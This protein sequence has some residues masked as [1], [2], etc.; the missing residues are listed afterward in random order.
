MAKKQ[1]LPPKA[2]K[3]DVTLA[4]DV[5]DGYICSKCGEVYEQRMDNFPRTNCPL[6][7]GNDRFMTTCNNCIIELFNQ[8]VKEFGN[9]MDAVKYICRIYW[10]YWNPAAFAATKSNSATV[11][12]IKAYFSKVNMAQYRRGNCWDDYIAQAQQVKEIGQEEEELKKI[13]SMLPE[14][15]PESTV[16]QI[17]RW[18]NSFT[19]QEHE[20]L[21]A[22]YELLA[23]SAE[24]PSDQEPIL[25]T[26][27]ETYILKSRAMRENDIDGFKKL[28]DLYSSYYKQLVKKDDKDA[29]EFGNI[30]FGVMTAIVEDYAPAEYYKDLELFKD[31]SGIGDYVQRNVFR[32]IKNLLTGDRSKDAAYTIEEETK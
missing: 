32:P 20:Q 29:K 9:E 21:D 13:D 12:R 27:C 11:P 5:V 8:K 30:P 28:S 16:V 18:G 24:N 25:K 1:A 4:S 19:P 31:Y 2:K 17:L 22:H 7:E 23:A 15:P 14:T 6:Y 26:L 10:L 3:V